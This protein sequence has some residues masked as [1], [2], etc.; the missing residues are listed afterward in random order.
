M[1]F[2]TKRRSSGTNEPVAAQLTGFKVDI[3]DSDDVDTPR[4]G[5]GSTSSSVTSLGVRKSAKWLIRGSKDYRDGVSSSGES[6]RSPL[7]VAK[8]G[9]MASLPWRKR[10]QH[11]QVGRRS[12][13]IS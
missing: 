7:A 1:R 9:M 6:P 11:E 10:D 13:V 3:S 4:S 12:F 2:F 5:R 8:K